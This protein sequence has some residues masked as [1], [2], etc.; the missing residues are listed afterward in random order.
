MLIP[1]EKF[2]VALVS[3]Q[4]P[5][6]AS[7]NGIATYTQN[8]LP[9]LVREGIEVFVM[10]RK[11][12]DKCQDPFVERLAVTDA[13]QPWIRRPISA[14]MMRMTPQLWAKRRASRSILD[15]LASLRLRADLKL[16]E[17]EEAQGFA[18]FVAAQ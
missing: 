17:M 7:A 6:G 4:W 10:S 5:A 8:L 3:P 16:L 18:P 14:L 15:G 1:A 9:S 11:V 12:D 2:A 13:S